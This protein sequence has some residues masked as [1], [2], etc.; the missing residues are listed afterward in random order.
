MTDT[1][2]T[3]RV[4]TT[5]HTATAL[6]DIV[7]PVCNEQR[8][9]EASVTRLVDFLAREFPYSHQI[10]IADNAST[11][12]TPVIADRLSRQLP[13]VR[14]VRLEQKGRGRAL[15]QV[16]A[17]S[18]SAVLAYMDVDLSTDLRALLPLVAPLVSGHSDV[19][20]GTRLSRGSRVVRGAKREFISRCYNLLLR[21]S[22]GVGFSD[23]QCGFKAV[24]RDVARGLLPLCEDNNWFFDTE[25]LVLA[26]RAG[27]R[28]HE[29]PV[30]WVD[31]PQSSVN[32]VAT[33]AEDLRG[34]ARLARGFA[35]GA[36]PL[37]RLRDEALA[38]RPMA[39]P[40]P[41]VPRG[42]VGQVVRFAGVGVASTIA[43]ALLYWLLRQ[44]MG[45]QA[46]N[47][48]ALVVTA[49]A[50]TAA[51]RALTFGVRG[52]DRLVTDHLGGLV[53]FAIGLGLTSG[54]LGLLHIWGAGSPRWVEL[55]VLTGANAMATVVRFL[56]LRRLMHA[57]ADG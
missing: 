45:A 24:R 46:A 53:A 33:A 13:G 9:L 4:A 54:S 14:W 50:N 57:R 56:V 17:Q 22:L 2:L 55:V 35:T 49:V 37:W 40:V 51:N 21:T 42:M 10:T 26:Q 34:M 12:D 28:I 23:A 16:W 32:I 39:A 27:L 7:I 5:D 47:F 48:V 43:Y 3:T 38:R 19:A 30:D 25:M 29:V 36:I 11:D 31:D 41:G 20:I 44:G 18:G 1:E 6:V 52:R 15:K 8:D